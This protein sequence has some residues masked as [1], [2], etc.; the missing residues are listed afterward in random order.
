M[1]MASG[2]HL[3]TVKDIARHVAFDKSEEGVSRVLRQIRHWTE[4]DLLRPAS[5]KN[6]GTGIPRLYL[7]EPTIEIIA[8]LLEVAR[9]GAT[10]DILKPVADALYDAEQGEYGAVF[11]LAQVG[12]GHAMLQISWKEDPKT[13][14]LYEAVVNFFTKDEPGVPEDDGELSFEPSSSILINLSKALERV[15]PLPGHPAFP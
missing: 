1:E 13:G 7:V 2:Q 11:N 8:V 4:S 5:R 15:Y 9:Y 3:L 12:E 6:T 14:R 10:V